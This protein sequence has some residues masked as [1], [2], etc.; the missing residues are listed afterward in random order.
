MGEEQQQ[1]LVTQR[2]ISI[3]VTH[4]ISPCAT[5]PPQTFRALQ[6]VLGRFLQQV[7]YIDLT[8][9]PTVPKNEPPN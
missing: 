3:C 6:D 1:N 8:S 4:H 7:E 9:R 2:H 5:P